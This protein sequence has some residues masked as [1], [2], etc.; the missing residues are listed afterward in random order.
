[1]M[2]KV[3]KG[4]T[5]QTELTPNRQNLKVFLHPSLRLPG[6]KKLGVWVCACARVHPHAF[7]CVHMLFVCVSVHLVHV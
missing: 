1:M 4:P 2:G 3:K 7:L 5:P 6:K